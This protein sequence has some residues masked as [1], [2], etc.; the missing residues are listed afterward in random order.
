[1]AKIFEE[2]IVITLSKVVK[3]GQEA[4]TNIDDE[5]LTSLESVVQELA[6]DTVVVEVTR[7]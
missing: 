1:M 7:G 5:L 3:N 4:N 6:G 2:T